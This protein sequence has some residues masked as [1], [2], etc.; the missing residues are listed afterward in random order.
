M[1]ISR[2]TT[3]VV[4]ACLSAAAAPA[5]EPVLIAVGSISGVYEDFATRTAAPLENGIAG[6][7]LGGMGSA[8]AWA[9]GNLFIAL[10]DRG[11]NA[12][13]Y[14]PLVDDTA[15]YILRFH[16]LHL[17]LAP[18]GDPNLPF[19]VTPMIVGTTLLS[20]RAPLFY[21]TGAG[22][23]VGNG[24]PPLNAV[25][26]VFYFSGRSDNFN[27][28]TLSTDPQDARL[29]PEGIRVSRNGR[30]VFVTDEY[31]PFVYE[32]DRQSGRRVRAFTLPDKFG[33]TVKSPVGSTEIGANTSGRVA[34]KGMEGLAIAP[35]GRTL[36][37]IMQSP[38]LQDGGANGLA[39]RIVRID[40]ASGKVSEFAYRLDSNKFTVSE[41]VAVNDHEF[42]VD[43]R[44][45]KGLND[46]SI[47]VQKKL[48]K[49]D[50]AG[51]TDVTNIVGSANL[52][53]N[54]VPKTLF[55]DVVSALNLKGIAAFDVPAKLEGVTFGPDVVM[56]GATRHTLIVANDN[57]Y[58]A[59]AVNSHHPGGTADNPN[60]WLVFAF[61][62]NDLP[63]FVPQ[64]FAG[65]D[66]GH[67]GE[68]GHDG[69]G[70]DR[71]RCD[72]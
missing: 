19:V 45:G 29:D 38:L 41:M 48:Y 10:P 18:S 47:A 60:K 12:K 57:D 53:A 15:S 50:L 8:L 7:L 56:G 72:Q 32:F 52:I 3:F 30:S 46:D 49:I 43:E 6:N 71:N 51:A 61:D 2:V 64:C 67:G 21:G 14:N 20:S 28:A 4:A 23:G 39:T 63:G 54:A 34:N 26:H 25:D 40:V 55:L 58:T 33:V 62:D 24:A 66:E 22:L 31:G 44:D 13:S 17:T 59:V 36:F 37:G 70:R 5:A 42:L 11:P 9:G 1:H 16:T 65:D 35:D 69:P 27:P 68:G